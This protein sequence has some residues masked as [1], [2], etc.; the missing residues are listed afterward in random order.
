MLSLLNVQQHIL[1]WFLNTCL[2]CWIFNDTFC[3]D[4]WT[5]AYFAEYSTTHPTVIPEHM[6]SFLNAQRHSL[7]WFLN[8]CLVSWMF[9]NTVFCDS[10]THAYFAEYSTTHPAVIPEHM[11]SLLNIQ[12]HILLW[13]LNTCLVC[14]IF[15]NIRILLWFLNTCLVCW[16]FN[17][18]VC[19]DSWTYTHFVE[20]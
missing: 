11:L 16:I 4:S 8:T 6:L 15:K 13:F 3:C 19:C 2:V 1:L 7:L 9:N 20:F 17:D 10:W 18:R 5:Y 12:Q 14:W